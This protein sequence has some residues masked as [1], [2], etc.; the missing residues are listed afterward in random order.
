MS[1]RRRDGVA[2]GECEGN[3]KGNGAGD[4]LESGF[5][6]DMTDFGVLLSPP[7]PSYPALAKRKKRT[8]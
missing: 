2:S 4:C 8:P 7:L 1:K 6:V 3:G 5:Q